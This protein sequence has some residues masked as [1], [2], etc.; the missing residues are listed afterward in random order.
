MNETRRL[1]APYG[2]VMLGNAQ[3]VL[4]QEIEGYGEEHYILRKK[5]NISDHC[6]KP[7]G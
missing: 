5:S 1:R 6:G 2:R 7:S 4:L 3:Y